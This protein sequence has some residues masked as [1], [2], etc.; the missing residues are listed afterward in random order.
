MAILVDGKAIA[1]DIL[2]EVCAQSAARSLVVEA[3]AVSPTAATES[4][5][6]IKTETAKEAGLELRVVRLPETSNENELILA[7]AEG[8]ADAV[9]VQLPLPPS[10][11]E[12]AVLDAIPLTK[13]ADV[14]SS[15]AYE[16][17]VNNET[18]AL[19]PLPR[20]LRVMR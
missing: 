14:L 9:I 5:L 10:L 2:Q 1:A 4:Y 3:I 15:L 18:G 13:D 11:N 8:T 16:R 7:A 12:R 6:R 19:V 20:S 17:F